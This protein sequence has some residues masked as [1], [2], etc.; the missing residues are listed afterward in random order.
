MTTERKKEL[1]AEG[2]SGGFAPAMKT[3]TLKK[4]PEYLHLTLSKVVPVAE[5]DS[6]ETSISEVYVKSRAV[7][8]VEKEEPV[9]SNWYDCFGGCGK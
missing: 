3:R 6:N 1:K 9:K 8:E 2:W 7:V 4:S 5:D